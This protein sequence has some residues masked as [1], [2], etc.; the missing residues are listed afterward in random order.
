MLRGNL[1]VLSFG[2]SR[3]GKNGK[4]EG[5]T[6]EWMNVYRQKINKI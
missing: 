3:E 6:S 5:K 4:V 2:T 1:F